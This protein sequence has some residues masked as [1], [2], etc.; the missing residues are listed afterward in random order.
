MKRESDIQKRE[1]SEM[2]Y[3]YI[4]VDEQDGV[5]MITM[6]DPKTRNAIGED[7]FE[8]ISKELDRL[9]ADPNLRCLVL[10]GKDPAFCSGANVRGMAKNI[11]SEE[12]SGKKK[13]LPEKPWD[14]M[15][16]RLN[17]PAY[18]EEE[19]KGIRSLPVRLHR[20]QKPSI[21]AVNGYAMGL[22]LGIALSCDIRFSSENANFSETFIMRGLVPADGSC[23]QLPR[24]IGLS[25]TFMLQYTGDRIDPDTALRMGMIS[26]VFPHEKMI[27]E[28]LNFAGRIAQSPT[29]SLGVIKWLVHRSLQVDFEKS[30]DLS[31]TAQS[32]SVDTF[33]H[34]EGV[35]AFLEKRKPQYKG[36]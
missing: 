6:D 5:M 35:Q 1:E 23:W 27:E 13:T 7:M 10:T 34:K 21:A 28:T 18:R 19:A 33:D 2:G 30:M 16:Q 32:I 24:M 31:F 8:E 29:Y 25:N 22:G 15:A 26:G 3:Q 4:H 36:K 20:L 14:A 12:D 9:E 11:Q 17:D